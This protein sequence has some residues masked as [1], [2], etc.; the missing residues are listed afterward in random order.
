MTWSI[1]FSGHD[2]LTGEEKSKLEKNIVEE[3]KTF[4]HSL[5]AKEGNKVITAIAVTNTTGSVNLTEEET[6]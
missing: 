5:M 4:A 2:D 6:T 3:A 1:N